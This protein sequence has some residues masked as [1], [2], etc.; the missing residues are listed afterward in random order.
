MKILSLL[1]EKDPDDNSNVV[2][3]L[4]Y[5][6]FR[7]HLC[8][9]FELLSINLYEFIKNNNFQGVS[10]RLVRGFAVQILM[11][12]RFMRQER[13][14]HCDLKVRGAG[15]GRGHGARA[16]RVV[17]SERWCEEVDC[18]FETHLFDEWVL[19]RQRFLSMANTPNPTPP[20]LPALLISLK[21]F[22]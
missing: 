15:A 18:R 21:T 7:H 1:R 16:T 5:F 2:H 12:L 13:I 4:D 3:M 6:Y 20:H 19:L 14:I 8:I 11:S 17:E 9:T 22:C 10:L